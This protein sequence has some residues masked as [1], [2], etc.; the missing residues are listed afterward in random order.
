LDLGLVVY[1]LPLPH[2]ALHQALAENSDVNLYTNHPQHQRQPSELVLMIV[3]GM[4]HQQYFHGQKIFLALGLL[5][6]YFPQSLLDIQTLIFQ[7]IKF[8]T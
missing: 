7:E 5:M 2:P 1:L 6:D 8:Y 4:V 3:K